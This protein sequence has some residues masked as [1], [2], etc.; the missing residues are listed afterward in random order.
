[1]KVEVDGQ[2]ILGDAEIIQ[3][4]YLQSI[5]NYVPRPK[6]DDALHFSKGIK[7]CLAMEGKFSSRLIF[8]ER[9]S[10]ALKIFDRKTLKFAEEI[11]LAD[12]PTPIGCPGGLLGGT[13]AKEVKDFGISGLDDADSKFAKLQFGP[14]DLILPKRESPKKMNNQSTR[15]LRD[16]DGSNLKTIILDFCRADI[17]KVVDHCS[18]KDSA[19]DEP[20]TTARVGL[21]EHQTGVCFDPQP[22]HRCHPD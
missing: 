14:N 7:K 13:I 8:L 11:G 2:K 12:I 3:K 4:A 16:T 10:S 5:K 1:M 17:R 19:A 9:D 22:W 18:D 15:E 20:Q 21:G 6:P